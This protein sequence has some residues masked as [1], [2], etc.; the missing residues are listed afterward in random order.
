MVEDAA[1]QRSKSIWKEK[2]TR[3]GK[4]K[5]QRSG[6]RQRISEGHGALTSNSQV[7]GLLSRSH[8]RLDKPT[9]DSVEFVDLRLDQRDQS[10]TTTWVK[11]GALKWGYRLGSCNP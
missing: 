7:D 8:V 10:Q 1:S 4:G 3:D 11:P 5:T 9:G 6:M 2:A